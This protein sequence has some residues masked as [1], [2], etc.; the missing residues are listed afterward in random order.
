MSFHTNCL[1]IGLLQSFGNK[2]LVAAVQ[3][4]QGFQTVYRR[5]LPRLTIANSPDF[6]QDGEVTINLRRILTEVGG[7]LQTPQQTVHWHYVVKKHFNRMFV[8]CNVSRSIASGKASLLV[9]IEQI[10][11]GFH[12]TLVT[13]VID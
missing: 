7:R 1:I 2:G 12:E 13:K 3:G 10:G 8:R 6:L 4:L 11:P 5:K 9:D